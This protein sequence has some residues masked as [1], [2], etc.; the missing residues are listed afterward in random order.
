MSRKKWVG[1]YSKGDQEIPPLTEEEV[2]RFA[3]EEIVLLL[4]GINNFGDKIYNYLKLPLKKVSDLVVAVEM[5][6][7]FDVRQFGEVI[8]AGTG[9]PSPEI[10]Q[11]IEGA[12][13]MMK[14]PNT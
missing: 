1:A 4:S 7:K 10:R 2:A 8:A 13:R 11:E 3:E 14:M 6:G 5:G 12:Y 9:T